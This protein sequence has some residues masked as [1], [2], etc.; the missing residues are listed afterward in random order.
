[1]QVQQPGGRVEAAAVPPPWLEPGWVRVEVVAAGVCGADLGTVATAD[2]AALPA[3]PGHEV[4]GRIA[5]LG[6]GVSGWQVGDRVAVGW[7]GGS[8]GTCELCRRGDV[9]HCAQRKVPGIDYPGGWADSI[10][11]PADA[12]ARIPDGLDFAEAAPPRVCRGDD[13]QCRARRRGPRRRARG[14]LRNRRSGAPSRAV[15]C[16]HGLRG[17]RDGTRFRTGAGGCGPRRRPLL[18]PGLG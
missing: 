10:T 16:C 15:C 4:A 7:F 1:M 11:V 3:T 2:P 8:C 5:A 12:L 13:V 6:D 14:D 9:V 17:G 18:R